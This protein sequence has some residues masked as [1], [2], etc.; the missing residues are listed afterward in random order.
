MKN[1]AYFK[2][3]NVREGIFF[4]ANKLWNH[5]NNWTMCLYLILRLWHLV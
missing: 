1:C 3:E 2:L 5:M 4:V